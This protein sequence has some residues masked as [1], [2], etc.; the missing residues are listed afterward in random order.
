MSWI[1]LYTHIIASMF[2]SE[3]LKLLQVPKILI[4]IWKRRTLSE[5]HSMQGYTVFLEPEQRQHFL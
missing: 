1:M 2:V 4:C 5:V 3:N